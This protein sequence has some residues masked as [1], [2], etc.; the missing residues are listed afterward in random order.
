MTDTIP[1]LGQLYRDHHGKLS[2]KWSLYL[3]TYDKVLAPFQSK[4]IDLLEIGVQNGG[5]LEIL[6]H[7]F[8]NATHLIGCDIDPLCEELTYDDPR[9]TVVIGDATNPQTR[10]GILSL[11][12]RFDLIVDDGSHRSSDV[13]HAFANYF[14]ALRDGGIYIIED[15]HCSY[16]QEFEGGIRYPYS[17]IAFFRELVDIVNQEHWGLDLERMDALAT[18]EKHYGPLLRE[19]DLANI[20]SVT[21]L[22]SLCI[23][24]KR[25][26]VHNQ[27]GH[28]VVAGDEAIVDPQSLEQIDT[29]ITVPDQRANP[30]SQPNNTHSPV[31]TA[32][33]ANSAPNLTKEP[34]N[35]FES[36]SLVDKHNET[37]IDLTRLLLKTDSQ[38]QDMQATYQQLSDQ[39][40]H[41]FRHERT[42]EGERNHYQ[43]DVQAL[44]SSRSWRY[45]RLLRFA[46]RSMRRIGRVLK[47]TATLSVRANNV[48]TNSEYQRWI[49]CFDTITE[50]DRSAIRAQIADWVDPPTISIVMP[51]YNTPRA[52]L[53]AAIESVR[54]QLYPNWELCIA[55]DASTA[56]HIRPMLDHYAA[57]DPR[58]KVLF[59]ETNGHICAASNS[60]LTLATGDYVGLLDH[61]D[62][63]SEHALYWMVNEILA[64]PETELIYSDLDKITTR[65]ERLDPYFKPDWNPDLL[66]G[67]NYVIHFL[68]IKRTQVLECGGFRK[69]FEGSQDWDL[70]LRLTENLSPSNIRHIPAVLYHWRISSQSAASSITAK[71]YALETGRRAVTEHFERVDEYVELSWTRNQL[72]LIS[73]FAVHGNPTIS[74][75]IPTY[76]MLDDLRRTIESVETAT[77]KSVEIIVIDNGS[78]DEATLSYLK[79]LD[80]LPS[81]QVLRYPFRFNY[82]DMHNWAIKQTKGEYV[83][84]LNN[85]IEAIE[86][87]WLEAML[88]TAQRK[89]IGAVG[90]KLLYPNDTIQHNGVVLGLGGIAGHALRYEPRDDSGPM[91]RFH[92]TQNMSAVTAACLLVSRAA[93]DL[94]GGL[95]PELPIAYNDVDFCLRLREAGLRNLWL[96]QALLYHHE[97]KSRGSDL[98]PDKL[99][100]FAIGHAYMEWRWG[101]LLQNDP[102]YNTNLTLTSEDFSLA[103]PP[104]T[105]RPWKDEA[106]VVNAP[107]TL[108]PAPNQYILLTTDNN[109]SGSFRLPLG[110]EH[111]LKAIRLQVLDYHNG[112]NT[113]IQLQVQD[114][115]GASAFG[116][117]T[118]VGT[119]TVSEIEI[120]LQPNLPLRRRTTLTYR[121]T[122]LSGSAPV[123]IIASKINSYWGQ[124]ITGYHDSALRARLILKTPT[125]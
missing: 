5:S 122:L 79:H 70:I 50:A 45:T 22:D 63:L 7:F 44:R 85:D 48:N 74:V 80:T 95:T 101:A 64:H 32:V 123:A 3:E 90:A 105:M 26:K 115:S 69:G 9:I 52:F 98:S 71:P 36:E 40:Q 110:I 76:N 102:A 114:E 81:Y 1:T 108:S 30:W 8:T 100:R 28:R 62:E 18:F 25:T 113:T 83:L 82:A 117:A 49:D 61:D 109:L 20:H 125:C 67:Q 93:W 68:V 42:L 124:D 103:W 66:L 89:G 116:T 31:I 10:Q 47:A 35:I 87:S 118:H 27:L 46:G 53:E 58:I 77:Y 65:G 29:Y 6:A 94:V 86:P 91:G 21:F 60:A 111:D 37:I 17:S 121:I 2:D 54:T 112:A 59:R 33:A 13:I 92:L 34:I 43:W 72:H 14:S 99:Q 19:H 57:Q 51:V 73:T 24:E 23:I 16:W 97:S 120:A 88:G 11:A 4:P 104:R 106:L 78:D 56:E 75:V 55:D 84:L 12:N 96:P 119:G 38:L 39:L 107:G 41:S 15:L